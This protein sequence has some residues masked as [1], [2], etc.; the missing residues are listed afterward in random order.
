MFQTDDTKFERYVF[1]AKAIALRGRICK[2]YFQEV[3]EHASIRTLA[4]SAGVLSASSEAYDLA[5][6]LS[7]SSATSK[8]TAR[9]DGKIFETLVETTITDL[10]IRKR[11]YVPRIVSRLRSSYNAGEY[12]TR[13]TPRILPAGSTIEGLQIDG[14]VQDLQLHP[15]FR[16]DDGQQDDFLSGR[17]Q[18]SGDDRTYY[19]GL[20]PDPIAIPDWGNI[21]YG[22]WA[23]VHP[24][25]QHRQRLCMLRLSLGSEFGASFDV[26]SADSDGNGWP[27]F[28]SGT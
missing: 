7:Y 23:W 4:G 10:K 14:K 25:E 16:L 17:A 20:V 11:F 5:G 27:P 24:G 6:D 18:V 19:P 13:K 8:I 3:G 26:A 2:P 9:G 22:E 1:N 15:A 28:A 21:Y 12:S